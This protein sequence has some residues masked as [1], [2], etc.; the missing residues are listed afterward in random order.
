VDAAVAQAFTRRLDPASRAP[1]AVA[2]S[3]GG[4]SLALLLAAKAWADAAGRTVIALSVDHGLQPASAGWMAQAAATAQRLGVR[5]QTL[6]WRG[7]KPACGLPAAARRARH[8]LIADAARAAGASVVLVGHTLDDQLENAVMRGAGVPVGPICEWS[9]SP[10]WPQGRGLFHFRPLLNLRRADLR[11]WLG[12]RGMGWIEDPAND[13]P[14]FARARARAALRDGLAAQP[15]L[16]ARSPALARAGSA[17]VFDSRGAIGVEPQALRRAQG[18]AA[19]R[20]LQI[21]IACASGQAG[22]ARPERARTLLR[23]LA[24]GERFTASLGGARIAADHRILIAR[25]PGEAARGGLAPLDLRAGVETVWDGRYALTA[26][27]PGL[28]VQGLQGLAA[29]LAQGERRALAQVPAALRGA[30]PAIL[31][32]AGEVHCPLLQERPAV[33]AIAL[34]GARLL[35]A[36]GVIETEAT[37]AINTHMA[38]APRTSYVGSEC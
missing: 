5:F 1:L 36:C 2:F 38:D 23:R 37:I 4:D 20:W 13:D 25:E 32:P 22:L 24:A 17:T 26:V 33:R 6:Q 14:R 15:G 19:L 34:G 12:G 3:G 31:D 7:D 8:A 10:A 35:A 21:A 28:T 11:V 30:L 29:K 27:R 16:A 9:P 18:D